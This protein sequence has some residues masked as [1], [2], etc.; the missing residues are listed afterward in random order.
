MHGTD[1]A[2]VITGTA[3]AELP[4][5]NAA[6]R[7]RR[8]LTATDPGQFQC[9]R[10]A[11]QRGGANGYGKF[12]INTAGWTRHDGHGPNEPVAGQ[13]P[14]RLD[15]GGDGRWHAAGADGDDA[16]HRR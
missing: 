10:G 6:Q 2:M 3:S 12:S 14:Q 16:R 1:D 8:T 4:E 7:R 11:D 5:T 13:D 9:V 15:H